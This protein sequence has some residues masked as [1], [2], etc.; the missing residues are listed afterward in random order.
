MVKVFITGANGLI[1]EAVALAFRRSGHHVFGLV[2]NDTTAVA[3]NLASNEVNLVV[4]ELAKPESYQA[5]ASTADILI[6]TAVDYEKFENIDGTAVKTLIDSASKRGKKKVTFIYTSGVLVYPH[7][8]KVQSE[9][10]P[11]DANALPFVKIRQQTEQN[12][13]YSDIVHGVVV[14]PGFVFGGRSENFTKYF[15]DAESGS[16]TV[17]GADIIWSE[18]HIHDLAA[19]YVKIGEAAPSV[20]GG[21]IFNIVD[22]SRNSNLVIATRFAEL[23]GF[24]G[25]IKQ[26]PGN[27][28]SGKSTIVDYRKATRLIGWIPK[29]KNM[30]DEAETY[31]KAWKARQ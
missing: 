24:K 12:I 14:R 3:K 23:A 21:Q 7:S 11:L 22:D 29:H 26:Q 20:V 9:D 31:Y 13:I 2:R 5:I 19:A 4:G 30:L 17:E 6:H 8:T 28:W 16:V 25:E 10:D 15:K 1:G 27:A 18:I